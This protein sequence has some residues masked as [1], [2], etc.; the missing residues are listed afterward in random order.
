MRLS[1][2][3]IALAAAATTIA[4]A[5]VLPAPRPL[6]VPVSWQLEFDF[7]K[8]QAI[9]VQLA[10]RDT[11]ETFWY[12]IY[13]VD[14]KT[15]DERIFVPEFVLYTDTGQVFRAGQKVPT[16]VFDKIKK[17]YNDPL[18]KDMASMT[19]K[20][21]QGADNAKSGV[22]IWPDIDPAAGAFD[23]FIG[24]LSGETVEIK[25]PAPIQVTEADAKGDKQTVEKKTIVLAKTL[26]LRYAIPGEATARLQTPTKLIEKDWIMR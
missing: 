8:P 17:V 18:L 12:M 22:A 20:L 1:T 14:N 7:Q 11:P 5:P 10:G 26:Y 6:E 24:G 15:G 2:A 9:Q 3:A 23:I 16:A 25:L 21:L 13:T 19:G 4:V